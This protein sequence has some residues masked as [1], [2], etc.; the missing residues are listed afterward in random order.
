MH[1]NSSQT[2]VC[3]TR[4]DRRNIEYMIRTDDKRLVAK[5]L[6]GLIDVYLQRD[7]EESDSGEEDEIQ[8]SAADCLKAA[9]ITLFGPGP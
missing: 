9:G 3:N 8:E 2:A 6:R 4:A 1:I 5:R 7:N